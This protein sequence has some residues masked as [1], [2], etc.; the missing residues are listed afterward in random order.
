MITKTTNSDGSRFYEKDKVKYPSVTTILQFYPKGLGFYK[1]LMKVGDKADEI[2]DTAGDRG[3]RIHKV[4]ETF[5]KHKK[6]SYKLEELISEEVDYVE[7][8]KKWFNSLENKEI[9]DIE[10]FVINKKVGYA[11][12]VDLILKM[13]G[14]SYIIDI[15]TGKSLH[16]THKLQLSAYKHCGYE[17]YKI[18]I[19]HLKKDSFEFIDIED[20]FNIFLAVKQIFDYESKKP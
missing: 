7:Q 17:D 16:T 10:K 20:D 5:L 19:L 2:R 14:V 9:I 13:N 4:I 8:F 15:K 11:G 18:A 3:S 6:V 1:W 12:T